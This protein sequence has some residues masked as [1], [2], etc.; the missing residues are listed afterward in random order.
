MK[1]SFLFSKV[2][3]VL[4]FLVSCNGYS[5][6]ILGAVSAGVNLSQVDGDEKYGFKKV[7]LNLGPSVIIPFGKNKKWSFSMELLFSQIGSRQKSQYQNDTVVDTTKGGYYDGYKLN[8]TYVQI[9]F[10]VHF[11]DKKIIAGGVGLLYGQLVGAQEWE[12]YNDGRGYVK[13]ETNLQGPYSMADLQAI[14]DIRLRLYQRLWFN[15][16]YSY[17]VFPIRT[18]EF[19]NPVYHNTWIR[20]QY[21]NVI[22]FRLTYIFNEEI[23]TRKGKKTTEE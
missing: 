14:V 5:Q 20:K 1:N 7:G 22:T 17:S 8:L 6:R 23:N 16:R 15:F 3:L 21:N 4:V 13:T 11:T 9:P 19:V 10:M 18:R 2:L 12:D